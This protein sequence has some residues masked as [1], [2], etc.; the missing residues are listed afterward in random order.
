VKARAPGLGTRA[1]TPSR[2]DDPHPHN[3]HSRNPQDVIG[4][5]LADGSD[6]D[7]SWFKN[8]VGRNHRIRKA[9]GTERLMVEPRR[10]FRAMVAVKQLAPGDRIRAPFGWRKGEP[11]LNS[12]ACAERMFQ[13]AFGGGGPKNII[14][15]TWWREREP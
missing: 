11:L 12:E 2:Q 14:A 5:G 6:D 9:L 4:A 7:R 13:A 10:G 1:T 3:P 15:T 8:H